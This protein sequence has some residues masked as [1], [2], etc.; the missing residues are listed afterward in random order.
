MERCTKDAGLPTPAIQRNGKWVLNHR[1]R[2]ANQEA[3]GGELFCWSWPSPYTTFPV[4]FSSPDRISSSVIPLLKRTCPFLYH[5]SKAI[6]ST[7]WI[8]EERVLDCI[9]LFLRV[10]SQQWLTIIHEP[11]W[12]NPI[13]RRHCFIIIHICMWPFPMTG[14]SDSDLIPYWNLSSVCSFA[15]RKNTGVSSQ[16]WQ[17]NIN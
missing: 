3:A 2:R 14:A 8:Q 12:P 1:N 15:R 7:L 4:S 10:W 16:C 17:S 6:K 13:L 9:L 11:L 5:V